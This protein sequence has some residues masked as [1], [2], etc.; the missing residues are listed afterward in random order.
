MN[1][2]GRD[3]REHSAVIAELRRLGR[4]LRE[5]Q[6]Q[7]DRIEAEKEQVLDGMRHAGP[8]PTG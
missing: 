2:S 7:L 5:L 4:E 1:A 3:E 6:E 8:G